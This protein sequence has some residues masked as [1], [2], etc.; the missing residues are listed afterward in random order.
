[1]ELEFTPDQD[2]LRDAV[3][4]VLGRECP[5]TF[6]REVAEKRSAGADVGAEPL[7]SRMVDLGWP[8]LT[9][10]EA[11]GGLGLGPIELTV[12]AEELGRALAPGPLLVTAS[13]FVPAVVEAGD[14]AQQA[15]LLGPVAAEGRT[16]ALAVR[17][18]GDD[19]PAH[20]TSTA[21]RDG[22]SWVL[23]GRKPTVA[24]ASGVDRF[25]VVAREPGTTGDDGI[26]AFVVPASAA[27][28]EITPLHGFDPTRSLGTVELRGVRIPA[29]DALGDPGR[30]TATAVRRAVEVATVALAVETVGVVQAIFDTTLEYAKQREQFGVPIGSFQAIKHKFADMLVVIERARAT[31]YFAALTIAEDDERRALAVSMAKAAAGD[32]Q[33]LVAKEGIQVHGGIGYT[34]EHDMHLFVRRAKADAALFGTAADHRQRVADRLDW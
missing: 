9:V 29:A 24:E 3:R 27:G 14:T 8:A 34:W 33:R 12:L 16:G 31:A 6:V 20:V 11:A 21:T 13:Q 22:E 19:D 7:W 1:M 2:E 26:G 5:T 25:V 18:R 4:T 15:R 23:D 17:D 32:A 10:P 30:T 28:V